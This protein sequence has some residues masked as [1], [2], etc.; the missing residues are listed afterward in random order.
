MPEVYLVSC[1]YLTLSEL[2]FLTSTP[3]LEGMSGEYPPATGSY[4]LV[5]VQLPM[6]QL[7]L[8]GFVA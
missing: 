5:Q 8:A 6:V 3:P 2:E 1:V 7:L 4:Q